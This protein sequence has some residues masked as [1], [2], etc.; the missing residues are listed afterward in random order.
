MAE[1]CSGS[2]AL[3]DFIA[4]MDCLSPN[5]GPRER[6]RIE[7]VLPRFFPSEACCKVDSLGAG[8]INDTYLVEFAYRAPVVLQRINAAVFPDP[9]VVARNFSVVSNHIGR[10]EREVDGVSVFPRVVTESGGEPYHLDETGG[11]WRAM[12]YIE[13]TASFRIADSERT[14]FEGG[15]IL[16]RFHALTAD[17]ESAELSQPLPGFHDLPGYCRFYRA[18][19]VTHRRTNSDELDYCCRAI[20]S[21]LKDA[22]ILELSRQQK[23]I[24]RR[25]IHGDPKCDNILFDRQTGKGVA[26]IDLDTVSPGLLQFD[27]GDC[28][29]SFCNAAGEKPETL[30][31]VRFD[32]DRCRQVLRGYRASGSE[33]IEPERA[34]IFQGVRLLTFELGV[35][36]LTDYLEGD[37]YFKVAQERD[38]LDRALVQIRLLESI[39]KQRSAIETVVAALP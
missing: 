5:I 16:G 18:A 13:N 27:L 6:S 35:R 38:N 12:D 32:I 15:R 21:R 26:L 28:L 17:L 39:E 19:C 23:L 7:T 37:T 36:F 24:H 30:E 31:E 9:A 10:K 20:N 25:V 8:N 1:G 14:A 2:P 3:S 34:L 11:V 22:S 29:R 4:R 33:L